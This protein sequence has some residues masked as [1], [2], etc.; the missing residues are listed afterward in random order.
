MSHGGPHTPESRGKQKAEVR[1]LGHKRKAFT[2]EEI[3]RM[4]RARESEVP[5]MEIARRFGISS[6][7]LTDLIGK[8]SVARD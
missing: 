6:R 4:F 3:G 2:R 1:S 8:K 7:K 5:D